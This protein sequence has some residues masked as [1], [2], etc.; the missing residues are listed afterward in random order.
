MENNYLIGLSENLIPTPALVLDADI[1][2]QNINT[3]MEYL[4]KTGVSIRPHTKT[5]KTPMIARQQIKSGAIGLCCATIGEAEAMV[6]AGLD[7]ILIANEVI[8]EDKI[9]RAVSLARYANMMVAIDDEENLADLSEA[10]S[11]IGVNIGVLIEVDV[12]MGRCGVRSVEDA[13]KLAKKAEESKGINFRGVM[14]YEGHAV[15]IQDREER[16]KA[17]HIANEILVKAAETIRK[18]GIAVEIVSGAG[19]GT[20]DIAAEY[21]GITEIQA[22]SYIFMDLTYAKLGI[23]FKQSLTVLATVVSRPT[24]DAVIMDC[25][26]KAISVERECPKLLDFEGLEILKLAEEHAK[27]HLLTGGKEPKAGDKLYLIPS[28]CCTTIN[29]HSKLYV[30]RKGKVEAIW[31][32]AARG[33]Y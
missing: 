17:G 4:K 3:M 5:H 30:I 19:T 25:G 29:L 15:F 33:A 6:N 11:A 16:T 10:A 1:F 9:R 27:A 26:M 31:P 24:D 14:G 28:H 18:A 32:I 12:G 22:G 20:Y 21:P 2:E 7:N 8:G 23:P 13:V